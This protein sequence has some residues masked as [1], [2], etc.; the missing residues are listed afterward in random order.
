M[1]L[2]FD[3]RMSHEE[4]EGVLHAPLLD[5]DSEDDVFAKALAEAMKAVGLFVRDY[6]DTRFMGEYIPVE[7]AWRKVADWM[8]GEICRTGDRRALLNMTVGEFLSLYAD[9]QRGLLDPAKDLGLVPLDE[10]N[11]R[12]NQYRKDPTKEEIAQVLAADLESKDVPEDA[13]DDAVHDEASMVGTQVNNGGV[14]EQVLYLLE[15][16]W[17][18]EDIR[19][20]VGR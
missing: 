11:E 19:K 12:D 14:F 4:I 16:G 15:N 7:T 2:N 9:T 20:E 10:R 13:L 8:H 3:K 5:G 17:S 6:T 1:A 18:P